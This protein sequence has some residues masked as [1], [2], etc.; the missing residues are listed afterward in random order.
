M[1]QKDVPE[2]QEGPNDNEG[3]FDDGDKGIIAIDLLDKK[4]KEDAGAD[5]YGNREKDDVFGHR[6][7]EDIAIEQGEEKI[8]QRGINMK[9]EE[10]VIQPG[11]PGQINGCDTGEEDQ[12]EINQDN[13]H[14]CPARPPGC[15][16]GDDRQDQQ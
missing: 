1:Q 3:G 4:G 7:R 5:E 10:V 16:V 6:G 2:K 12:Y 13:F 11:N 9:E 15:Q 8:L 14:G